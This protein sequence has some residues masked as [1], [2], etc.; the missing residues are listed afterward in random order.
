MQNQ[1]WEQVKELL[2]QVL[3]LEAAE[4]YAFLNDSAVA[5][6]VRAEV[7]SLLAFEDE[8]EDLMRLSAVEFSKDFFDFFL[9]L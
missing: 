7:E 9:I 4:R 2:Q 3:T 8:A 5:P 6:E 1:N